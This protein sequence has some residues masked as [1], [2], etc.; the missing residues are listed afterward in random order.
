MIIKRMAPF[1]CAKVV[2]AIYATFMLLIVCMA[3]IVS[4]ISMIT[5]IATAGVRLRSPA[6][7]SRSGLSS[8][9]CMGL[10]RFLPHSLAPGYTMR[11]PGFWAGSKWK[12]NKLFRVFDRQIG[13]GTIG[14]HFR[15]I[16]K[17]GGGQ[18]DLHCLVGLV[19]PEPSVNPGGRCDEGSV[20]VILSYLVVELVAFK[21]V[22]VGLLIGFAVEFELTFASAFHE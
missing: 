3:T 5:R 11:W 18:M 9:F 7:D 12:S 4:L 8:R 14:I 13:R 1:S 15:G 21:V 6:S 16:V 10:R 22:F 17:A 20:G 19:F 2:G